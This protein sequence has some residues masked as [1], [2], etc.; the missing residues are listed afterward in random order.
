MASASARSKPRA[1]REPT[2]ERPSVALLD[3]R[4]RV[5][6]A[7]SRAMVKLIHGWLVR[8]GRDVVNQEMRRSGIRASAVLPISK[9]RKEQD[10]LTDELRDILLHFGMRQ[11]KE[12]S[13][14]AVG[15]DVPLVESFIMR[16]FFAGKEALIQNLAAATRDRIRAA[17]RETI[18][19]AVKEIP[20]PSPGEIAQRIRARFEPGNDLNFTLSV[21]RAATIAR[22]ELSQAQNTG[23]VAGYELVGIKR[24]EWLGYSDGRSGKRRHEKMIGMTVELGKK[25]TN[26]TTGKKLRYPGD[27]M[28]HISETAN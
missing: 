23:I 21:G 20:R 15:L 27:P 3:R 14:Q 22:T 7:R 17:V 26:P 16:D 12:S 5:V 18:Q 2:L 24:I 4:N 19:G 28:A 11:A 13:N 1:S 25:F 9:G 6:D 10:K 8:F